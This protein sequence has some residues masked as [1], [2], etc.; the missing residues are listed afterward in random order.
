MLVPC[1]GDKATPTE[2]PMSTLWEQSS[3]DSEI[4]PT[5][6]REIL[7]ISSL[8]LDLR[9]EDR[10]LV[11]GKAGE[12]RP[13]TRI[14][15]E[16]GV[17]DHSKSV[18]DHDQEL[19]TARMPEAVIDHLEAVEIDEQHRRAHAACRLREQLVG[20]RTEMQA[21]WKRGHGIVHAERVRILDRRPNLR[22]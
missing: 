3:K 14:A 1:S 12:Q 17:D 22:E 10:E 2:A 6:R 20:L 13:G 21:V 11:A 16:L 4:A 5:M 15:R 18:R 19:V 8:D 7:S 9:E